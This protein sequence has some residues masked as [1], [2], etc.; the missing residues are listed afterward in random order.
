MR[1][2]L[3]LDF[4]ERFAPDEFFFGV[5]YAP[6]CEGGLNG[7]DGLKNSDWTRRT[8]EQRTEA[9][10]GIRFWTNYAEHVRLA[11]SLGLNA[12]R[13]GIEWARCQPSASTE[14]TDPPPWDEAALDHYADMVE[15][16]IDHGMQP[17]VTLHHFTHP[18][19]LGLDIWLE[20]RG[21]DVLIDA[22]IRIVDEI[23]TRLMARGDE[24]MEHFLVYN[25]PNLIPLFY[26]SLGWYPVE[27]TGPQYLLSA[28]DTMLSPLHQGV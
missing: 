1:L 17:I 6:Y 15:T 24:K 3:D 19:W 2:E 13:L 10:E 25:E 21:P 22:Q 16:V 5:A 14:P 20:D 18:L 11:A 9:S 28:F 23:N 8:P 7:P 12:F 4:R 26:H 27:R